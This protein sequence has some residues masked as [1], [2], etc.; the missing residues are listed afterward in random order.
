LPTDQKIP[1]NF[2]LSISTLQPRK[3]YVNCIKAFAEVKKREK[4]LK[5]LIIGKKGW[6][7]KDIFNCGKLSCRMMSFFLIM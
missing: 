1:E 2:I 6:M 7:Y 5:Y 3:N 4:G